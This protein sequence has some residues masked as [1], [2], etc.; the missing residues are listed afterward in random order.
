[1]WGERA[2]PARL[3]KGALVKFNSSHY[4]SVSAAQTEATL[5]LWATVHVS[6]SSYTLFTLLCPILGLIKAGRVEFGKPCNHCFTGAWWARSRGLHFI[7][8]L[9]CKISIFVQKL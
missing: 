9:F 2:I 5:T 8:S 1:M 4:P 7:M 3:A 6:G